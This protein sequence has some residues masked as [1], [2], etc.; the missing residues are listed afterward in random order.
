MKRCTRP[1]AH[2]YV[3]STFLPED[4]PAVLEL[5]KEASGLTW[6][7]LANVLGVD[8]RQLQRWRSGTKPSGDGL[9]ALMQLA[10]QI[11][12]CVEMILRMQVVPDSGPF[13]PA[14]LLSAQAV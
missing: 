7:E 5:V 9:Y 4:F 3:D 1:R 13:R 14:G 8:P 2:L 6:D 12:G 11:P 10:A